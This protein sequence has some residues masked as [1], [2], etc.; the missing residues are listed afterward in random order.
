M[1][2]SCA[3]IKSSSILFKYRLNKIEYLLNKSQK[4]N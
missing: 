1:S 2:C 4:D 3:N